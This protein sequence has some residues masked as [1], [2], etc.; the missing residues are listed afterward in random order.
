VCS[1]RER[2]FAAQS[3]EPFFPEFISYIYVT[4]I[5]FITVPDIYLKPCSMQTHELERSSSSI[6]HLKRVYTIIIGSI[7]CFLIAQQFF[8]HLSTSKSKAYSTQINLAGKQRTYSQKIAKLS[9]L[10]QQGKDSR[11]DLMKNVKI[12]NEAYHD[13]LQGDEAKGIAP[14]VT[15]EILAE[16]HMLD[17]FHD[18]VTSDVNC[19][20]ASSGDVQSGCLN[21]ILS[22]TELFLVE[23]DKIVSIYEANGKQSIQSI[24]N[25]EYTMTFIAILIVLLEVIFVFRPTSKL[26]QDQE[27]SLR[28]KIKDLTDS[29]NYAKKVQDTILPEHKK[30][31]D[32]FSEAFVLYMPKDIVAGD[33]YLIEQV[34]S[35]EN[36]TSG[37]AASDIVLFAVGD[38]TGHGVPGA[39]V[40]IICHNAMDKVIKEQKLTEPSDILDRVNELVQ[41]AFSKGEGGISD[42]MDMSICCLNPVTRQLCWAGANIPLWIVRPGQDKT[43][44]IE[45]K[46]DKQPIGRYVTNKPFTKHTVELKENDSI[47]LFSDG[48]SYQFGGVNV[49]K[50]TSRQLQ[51]LLID[52]GH[53]EMS[54]TKAALEAALKNWKGKLEQVDDITV[55][56]L[57]F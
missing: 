8:V 56:G 51:Q 28:Q 45:L 9:I 6:S 13:L 48:Y 52:H 34:R 18:K 36:I 12:W 31:A 38:C 33:F 5:F 17:S 39:M 10:Y 7:L 2:G 55:I 4:E 22:D 23:M 53:E 24:T 27:N 15:A 46:P 32:H 21:S 57:R 1:A 3:T 42:G 19:L 49:K 47:Y 26:I 35:L 44:V 41:Q 37:S 50:I 20:L 16:L 14:P 43:E 11:A 40:S 30:F 54:T 29:I 25:V